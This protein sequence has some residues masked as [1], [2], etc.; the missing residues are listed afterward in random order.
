MQEEHSVQ[1]EGEDITEA[2]ADSPRAAV[3]V[4]VHVL[5]PEEA[6]PDALRRILLLFPK[7]VQRMNKKNIL[8]KNFFMI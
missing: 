3:P 2:A 4:H 6:E 5:V 7:F 8:Q 1:L